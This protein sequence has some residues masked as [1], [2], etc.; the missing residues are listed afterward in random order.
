MRH[1]QTNAPLVY[2]IGDIAVSR[3]SIRHIKKYVGHVVKVDCV[4]KNGRIIRIKKVTV[5]QKAEK[6][7]G[8]LTVAQL[9]R[10][11][12]SSSSETIANYRNKVMG[13]SGLANS[14]KIY[15]P[16][17]YQI[18]LDKG[19]G[20]IIIKKINLPESLRKALWS[21]KTGAIGLSFKGKWVSNETGSFIFKEIEAIN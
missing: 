14:I 1:R 8:F 13:F 9:E 2:R 20:N 7:K 4:I 12:L 17:E 3:G 16:R 21:S 6:I 10:L 15:S 5:A 11:Y 18:N 19:K